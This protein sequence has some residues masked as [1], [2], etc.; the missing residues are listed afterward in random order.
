M[1]HTLDIE[2]YP[3]TDMVDKLPEPK[4]AYGNTKDPEKRAI[5]LAEARAE[6]V[7]KMALNPLFGRVACVGVNDTCHMVSK[8]NDDESEAA[9]LKEI[10]EK[11]LTVGQEHTI[12]TWNGMGFDFPFLYKRVAILKCFIH[13]THRL[14]WWM[15]RYNTR[16][17]CDLMQV[18]SNWYGYE[19]LDTVAGALLGEKKVEFDVSEIAELMKTSEGREKVS[20]YNL[21]DC[22]LTSGVYD[23]LDGVLF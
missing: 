9:L 20:T 3:N 17:H 13:G 7:D 21:Y 14:S 12:V 2:T 22:T 23:M 8:I 4:V 19:K 18:W 1:I 6:Q 16:P 11:Y 15:R 5:K 10:Q